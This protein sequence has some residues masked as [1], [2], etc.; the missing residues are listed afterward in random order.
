MKTLFPAVIASFFLVTTGGFVM[1]PQAWAQAPGDVGSAQCREVQLAAQAAVASGG[2]Y[3]NHGA[4]VRT[5]AKVVSQAEEAGTIT[6]ACSSCIMNQFAR[7]IPIE[8]QTPCGVIPGFCVPL[9]SGTGCTAGATGCLVPCE[10]APDC[11]CVSTTEGT[12]ACV[13]PICT[14]IP[15]SSSGECSGG[16]CFTQ[17]CCGSPG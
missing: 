3:A 17:G 8:Q 11:D 9:C 14:G 13:V 6:E 7:S 4:L 5:A 12:A 10:G 2:P 16:V 1:A 15:C